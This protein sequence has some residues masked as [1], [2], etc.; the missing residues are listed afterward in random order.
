M[1]DTPDKPA[2]RT[3]T[4]PAVA[5]QSKKATFAFGA[6]GGIL[7]VV[8][9]YFGAMAFAQLFIGVYPALRGWSEDE[10]NAWLSD[11]AAAQFVFV[12]VVEVLTILFLYV[13]MRQ[14]KVHFRDIGL[15]RP[16]LHDFAVSLAAYVPYFLLNAAAIVTASALLHVDTSQ[17]QQ[18]GFESARST[19]DLLLT[20]VSLVILPPI[21]EEIVMR[22]F[23]FSGLKRS[24]PVIK[25]A[26]VT[27]IIFAIAH[28]QFGSGAPL[29]WVAA[30]DTFILSLVLCYLR[31]RTGSLWAGIGLH[32]LKNGLAFFAIF[33]LPKFQ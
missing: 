2:A 27:S 24:L 13:I 11:S 15:V 29:L 5:P 6:I 22:G 18:T 20:F 8:A 10:T 12:L 17:Q 31:Q 32:A 33:I 25:A 4:I 21:V 9:V 26:I 14:R 1:S 3:V 16:R 28:L 30:I 19:T 7:A 23:L